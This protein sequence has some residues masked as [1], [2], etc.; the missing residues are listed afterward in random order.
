MPLR[1]ARRRISDGGAVPSRCTCSS[2]LATT[3][4]ALAGGGPRARLKPGPGAPAADDVDARVVVAAAVVDAA[5]GPR[6][7]HPGGPDVGPARLRS[8]GPGRALRHV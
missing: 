7:A 6:E 5:V 1:C 8:R 3:G 2:A 4:S